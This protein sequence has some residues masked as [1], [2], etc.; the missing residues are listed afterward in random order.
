[1]VVQHRNGSR[2]GIK[3]AQGFVFA[4]RLVVTRYDTMI[5]NTPRRRR[6]RDRD[7]RAAVRVITTDSRRRVDSKRFRAVRR[8]G[9]VSAYNSAYRELIGDGQPDSMVGPPYGLRNPIA[10][11]LL[12]QRASAIA[13]DISE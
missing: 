6:A 10:D 8:P 4:I 12:S 2:A 5:E 3:L 9:S 11:R 13:H 1:L 7:S